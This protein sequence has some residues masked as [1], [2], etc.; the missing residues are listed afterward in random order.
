MKRVFKQCVELMFILFFMN[1]CCT[2][3]R[4][5]SSVFIKSESTTTDY[6]NQV[7]DVKVEHVTK[8]KKYYHVLQLIETNSPLVFNKDSIYASGTD[9]LE[10][11]YVVE[12]QKWEKRDVVTASSKS[13]I[14][15]YFKGRQA[16]GDTIR[17]VEKG[18]NHHGDSIVISFKLPENQEEWDQYFRNEKDDE[19][20]H[21]IDKIINIHG[22]M[23]I[24]DSMIYK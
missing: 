24:G 21:K 5:I 14:W 20:R 4:P 18:V 19:I 1:S 12:N 15:F 7:L 6:V 16:P 22:T 23:E 17:I 13:L 11:L 8:K 3:L 2:T 9:Q 10:K